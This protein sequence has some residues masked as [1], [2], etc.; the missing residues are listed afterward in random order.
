MNA[1]KAKIGDI[2]QN[3]RLTSYE[4]WYKLTNAHVRSAVHVDDSLEQA[5]LDQKAYQQYVS[6]DP[7][8]ALYDQLEQ[9]EG[10]VITPVMRKVSSLISYNEN[11]LTQAVLEMEQE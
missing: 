11:L 2:F 4:G 7:A 1:S 9:M 8:V 6:S 5:V 3:S 10:Q